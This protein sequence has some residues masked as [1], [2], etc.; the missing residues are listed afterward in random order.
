MH[1]NNDTKCDSAALR[2]C[3]SKGTDDFSLIVRL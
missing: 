1:K 2:C 3:E